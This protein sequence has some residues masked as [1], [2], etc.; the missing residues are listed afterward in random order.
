MSVP[1]RIGELARFLPEKE[2]SV[3]STLSRSRMGPGKP[4]VHLI[5]LI[6]RLA[7]RSPVAEPRKPSRR[8]QEAEARGAAFR[9][10]E[11]LCDH[12]PD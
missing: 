2:V 5:D 9:L 12:A 1:Q 4:P 6:D 10:N 3:E 7:R 11:A 8:E